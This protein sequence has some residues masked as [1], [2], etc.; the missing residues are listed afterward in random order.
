MIF[1]DMTMNLCR[2]REEVF[3]LYETKCILF[4]KENE[5]P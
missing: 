1:Y 2:N 3:H 4:Q 5:I